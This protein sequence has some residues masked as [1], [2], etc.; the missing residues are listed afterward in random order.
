MSQ[1]TNDGCT[2]ATVDDKGLTRAVHKADS[3]PAYRW[4]VFAAVS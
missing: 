1:I 3:W 2:H 4:Y